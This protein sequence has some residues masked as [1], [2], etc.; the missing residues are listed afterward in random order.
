M[1]PNSAYP[2]SPIPT[3]ANR[4]A[5]AAL[6]I[7]AVL[8]AGGLAAIGQLTAEVVP[9]TPTYVDFP[10]SDPVAAAQHIRTYGY[11]LFLQ[12]DPTETHRLMPFFH[13]TVHVVAV[14]CL[15]FSLRNW[16]F[17]VVGATMVSSG[18]LWSLT[19]MRYGKM[20][21]PDCLAHSLGVMAVAALLWLLTCPNRRRC[22][23][24]A[25]LAV[26]SAYQCRPAYVFL[27]PLLPCLGI[28]LR[29]WQTDQMRPAWRDLIGFGGKLAL[30]TLAPL[31][32]FGSY[33]F[34]MVGHF[35]LVAFGGYNAA[36]IVCQ[37]LEEDD[38]PKLPEDVQELAT[39]S[40]E[41]REV[42]YA[43]HGWSTEPT[44]S[45][46]NL[47]ERFDA[48]TWGIF[49]PT[50]KEM[51]PDEPLTV[52]RR[53][54][55]LARSTVRLH[56]RKYLV[57]LFKSAIRGV[58]LLAS[59]W[60]RNLF[61]AVMLPLSVVLY[62]ARIK[63]SRDRPTNQVGESD[64]DIVAIPLMIGLSF[65]ITNLCLVIVTTPPLGRFMDPAAVWL[66]AILGAIVYQQWRMLLKYS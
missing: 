51:W 65:A 64:R 1:E 11:P 26:F 25:G 57:W 41:R 32:L 15:F 62:L 3:S 14:L 40:L 43:P 5:V 31:L 8:M 12:L 22:W 2:T 37:F 7:Q 28:L 30:W 24:S 50:A 29:W 60:I 45:Y 47:E 33:R 36:G 20:L 16:G 38:I 52:N 19:L 4:W 66:P 61:V 53:L 55:K 9:D 13:L 58:D 23:F 6:L 35:G 49:V 34:L 54:S 44:T 39:R 46:F 59:Y 48:N 10:L 42:V 63:I 56:P 21:T 18:I 27:V 17:A